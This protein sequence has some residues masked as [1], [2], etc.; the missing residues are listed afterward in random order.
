MT[1]ILR[2]TVMAAA[3]CAV[4]AG[5]QP[6]AA[7]PASVVSGDAQQALGEQLA[8]QGLPQQGVAAC[9]S[10]HGPRG[11]GQAAGG[12]PRIAGQ[13]AA[14]LQRQLQAYAQGSRPHPVMTPMAQALSAAQ[15]AAVSAHYAR[16]GFPGAPPA[17]GAGAARP[18]EAAG[19]ADLARGRMLATRG[20]EALQLQA[21]ANCHGPAGA[22]QPPDSPFLAAQHA[23]Y[24]QA[25]LSAWR[26]G[27]RRTDPSGQMPA[28]AQR[29]SQ[30]DVAA[31][32]AYYASL[33]W[34]ST[35]SR[36]ARPAVAAR[37][38]A[39][40]PGGPQGRPQG[41]GTEQGAPLTGGGQGPGGGGATQQPAR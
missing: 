12:F 36:V 38:S 33:P 7:S 34:V 15:V 17:P 35:A 28:I 31:V 19:A 22:G 6:D 1:L 30:A 11:E 37:P 13:S 27:E 21:C 23:S 41:T 16:Q 14:Y 29:L 32:S 26:S 24:L 18:A 4:Q 9:A 10:C 39:P 8:S 25:T 3:L 40:G 2:V 5:A 20:D